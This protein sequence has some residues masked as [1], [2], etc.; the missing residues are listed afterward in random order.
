MRKYSVSITMIKLLFFS[1]V[2]VVVLGTSVFHMSASHAASI[3]PS[4]DHYIY[5]P[6][7]T[8]TKGQIFG[9]VTLSGAPAG[10]VPLVLQLEVNSS[11]PFTLTTITDANGYYSFT[12]MPSTGSNA[13]YQVSFSNHSAAPDGRLVG[14]TT[15]AFT[16]SEG[17]TVVLASFDIADVSLIFPSDE[18]NILLPTTFRWTPRPFTPSDNYRLFLGEHYYGLG[19]W[20]G[21]LVGYADSYTLSSRPISIPPY[22]RCWWQIVID[23][24]GY[25]HGISHTRNITVSAMNQ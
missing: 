9:R 21:P 16:Y 19:A 7:V 11:I 12:G 10:D 1:I 13:V 18:A 24:A 15:T 20:Y 4:Q 14:W 23:N 5:F 6:L 22:C 8:V 2:L 3:S 25:G 17:S